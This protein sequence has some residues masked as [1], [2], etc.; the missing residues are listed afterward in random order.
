MVC[1]RLRIMIK[2]SKKNQKEQNTKNDKIRLKG[3]YSPFRDVYVPSGNYKIENLF[4]KIKYS[5]ISGSYDV[6]NRF[7]NEALFNSESINNLDSFVVQL[8]DYEGKIL[9]QTKDHNFTLMIVEKHEVLKETNINSRT[10]SVNIGGL[11]PVERNS[12]SN[13]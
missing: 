12:F 3:R 5:S 6:D 10:G 9:S 8:V 11:K 2:S 1:E 7:V 13:S 4:A